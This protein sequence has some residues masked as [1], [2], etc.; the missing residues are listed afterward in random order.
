MR[1]QHL[2]D[3]SAGQAS[4]AVWH[5]GLFSPLA[6]CVL[7]LLQ[8][9]AHRR[10]VSCVDF[11]EDELVVVVCAAIRRVVDPLQVVLDALLSDAAVRAPVSYTHLTLPT[12]REV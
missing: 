5:D 6:A 2:R 1:K 10:R 8:H 3:T 12:N 7:T 9:E 11:V 4:A